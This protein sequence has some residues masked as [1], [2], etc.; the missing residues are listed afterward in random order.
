MKGTKPKLFR[1]DF[2]ETSHGFLEVEAVDEKE[3]KEK[4]LKLLQGENFVI[5]ESHIVIDRIS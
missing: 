1:V 2:T 3:A 4:A 5:H